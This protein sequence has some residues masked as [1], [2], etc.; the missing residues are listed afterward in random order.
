VHLKDNETL[1]V[2][3]EGRWG[4]GSSKSC[5]RFMEGEESEASVERRG[6]E[7]EHAIV[8]GNA[9]KEGKSLLL[10]GRSESESKEERG[11]DGLMEGGGEVD[12][13]AESKSALNPREEN[14][15][16]SRV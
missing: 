15:A 14:G 5:A 7:K 13:L 16:L 11:G 10:K 9:R 1:H 2:K 6:G 8:G 12:N 3:M 4:E